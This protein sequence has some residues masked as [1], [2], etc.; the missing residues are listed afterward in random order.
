MRRVDYTGQKFGHLTVLEM[1]YGY[2]KHGEAY[3]R[4]VCECGNE[5]IKGS[6]DIR[7]S[8]YPAHCGCKTEEYKWDQSRKSRVDLVGKRFGRLV[9]TEMI[10]KDGEHTKVRCKCDCGNEIVRIA[11]YLTSGETQSCGCYHKQRTSETNV[12]DFTGVISNYGIELLSQDHKNNRGVWLWKCKCHCGN[13][14]T[15]LPANI[16]SGHIIS[17]GCVNKSSGE[18]LISNIL[19]KNNIKYKTEYKFSNCKDIRLLPF[20]FYVPEYRVAI[21]YQGKQHYTP[22]EWFGGESYY[23]KQVYHDNIK[24]EYCSSNNIDL[25]EIPYTMTDNEIEKLIQ[26][27]FIRRD[28]N[29]LCSNI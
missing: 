20:D 14:F 29:G 22:I 26:T 3:C 19:D 10:Y 15:A 17:C 2:G 7:H 8:R 25:I 1:L 28:C 6:Y 16:I 27:L 4:C 11:T 9:V 21:E 13:T 23:K 12:K 5:V 24:R 18:L